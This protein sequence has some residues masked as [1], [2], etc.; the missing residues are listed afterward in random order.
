MRSLTGFEWP[1]AFTEEI[2]FQFAERHAHETTRN[3]TE[4]PLEPQDCTMELSQ[5]NTY[6]NITSADSNYFTQIGPYL[7]AMVNE[8]SGEPE[9]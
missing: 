8:S 9:A 2:S 3:H 7:S 4:D 6:I 5:L 1:S